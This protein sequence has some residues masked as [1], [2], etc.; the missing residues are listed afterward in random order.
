[1]FVFECLGCEIVIQQLCL[2]LV[3]V[4]LKLPRTQELPPP[5]WNELKKGVSY[6]CQ[7]PARSPKSTGIIPSVLTP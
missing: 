7:T 4:S 1:M 2:Y 5:P 6:L 3:R